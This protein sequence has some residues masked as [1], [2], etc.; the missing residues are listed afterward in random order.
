MINN[1]LWY[2]SDEP[3]AAVLNVG[4]QLWESQGHERIQLAEDSLAL[5]LGSRRHSITGSNPTGLMALMGVE[6]SSSYNVIQA[7]A[8]T[9]IS[10][11]LRNKVRPLFVTEGGD[12]ELRAR[13]ADMQAAVD[14]LLYGFGMQGELGTQVCSAGYL[15]EAGGVEWTA[16]VANSRV[17]ATPVWPWE[18]YV[19]KREARLGNP[20]QLFARQLVDRDVLLAFLKDAPASVREAVKN[21]KS[22]KWED[23]ADDL[24]DPTML[25][26][27]VTIWKA[28]HLPSG[29]VDMKDSRAFG[30][31]KDGH[32][33]QA[34]HDGRHIVVIDGGPPDSPALIDVPWPYDAFPISW[35]KPNYVP[36]SWW[37]RGVPEILA[38]TQIELNKWNNRILRILD[39]H[40]RPLI[41]LWK[42]A[43]LNPAQINNALANIFQVDVQPSQAL[44]QVTPPSVPADLLNRIA[45][46]TQNA[47]DQLGLSEMSMMARKPAGVDHEPGMA[48]LADTETIRHTTKFKAWEQFNL[49]SAQQ[50][51]RCLR[52]LAENDNNFELV[53]ESDNELKRT[54]WREIDVDADKYMVKAWPTNFLKQAP[55]Q[56]ADQIMDFV[57]RGLFSPE[58]ALEALDAPDIQALIGDRAAI[59]QNIERKLD[60]IVG[61]TYDATTMP[62]PYMDLAMCRQLGIV[63]Y[64]FLEANDEK[65]DKVDRVVKFLEDVDALIAKQAPPVAPA[66]APGA[67]PPQAA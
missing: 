41:F 11:T 29:R 47:R 48:Y 60:K 64:N 51:I 37:S 14:G 9:Q 12:S 4:K 16:D 17:T 55:A 57:D 3:A 28:W 63:R 19:S 38:S 26:D 32:R 23:I 36:G 18:Y 42:Q 21:A 40:A 65:Q 53:F 46:V 39:L 61:G 20:R 45:Q 15:F 58:M 52:T 22:A 59:A 25:Q 30:K 27:Q 67:Q 10:H 56:R 8:D 2:Q 49:D 66:G 35:F 31:N 33:V 7:I 13:V 5:Y 54:K 6:G 43:K 62:T 24:K 1:E 44:H 34:N 50:I